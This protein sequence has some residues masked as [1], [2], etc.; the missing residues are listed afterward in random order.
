MG[1]HAGVGVMGVCRWC[2]GVEIPN[3][4]KTERQKDKNIKGRNKTEGKIKTKEQREKNKN[5]KCQIE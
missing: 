3:E 1:V 5:A 4:G 2:V